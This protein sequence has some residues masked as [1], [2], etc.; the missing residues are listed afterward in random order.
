V[1]L[2]AGASASNISQ[3]KANREEEVGREAGEP[4]ETT[5][6]RSSILSLEDLSVNPE[7]RHLNDFD[8]Q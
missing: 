6:G 2:R 7:R 3:G 8:N 4:V 1:A 5:P